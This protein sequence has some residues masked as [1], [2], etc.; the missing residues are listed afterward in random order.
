M[1]RRRLLWGLLAIAGVLVLILALAGVFAPEARRE[2]TVDRPLDREPITDDK[3]LGVLRDFQ[4]AGTDWTLKAPEAVVNRDETTSLTNPEVHV[5]RTLD[6]GEQ[7]VVARASRGLLIRQP[8][9]QMNLSGGVKADLSGLYT[10]TISAPSMAVDLALG[11]GRSSDRVEIV[12]RT[13][14]GSHSL[15][16]TGV[17]LDPRQ[18]TLRIARDIAAAILA[19]SRVISA[20]ETSGTSRPVPPI[21]IT[22]AGPAAADGFERAVRLQNAVHFRQGSDELQADRVNLF[23]SQEKTAAPRTSALEGRTDIERFEAEG[24]V[25]FKTSVAEGGGARL[26]RTRLNDQVTL[27]GAPATVRQGGSRITS[28]RMD[29][30]T[31]RTC[32]DVPGKGALEA[33]QEGEN[34]DRIEVSWG[35]MM[36]FDAATHDVAFRGEVRLKRQGLQIDCQSLNARLDKDNRRLLSCRAEG[37]VRISGLASVEKERPAE[38]V[39]ARSRELLYDAQKDSLRL[40]GDAVARRGA[41]EVRGNDIE[42]GLK[43]A[44]LRVAGAGTLKAQAPEGD[45]RPALEA[46]WS[47]DMAYSRADGK[48]RLRRGVSIAQGAQTLKAD[49]VEVRLTEDGRAQGLAA[50]GNVEIVEEGRLLRAE[51]LTARFGAENALEE[52]VATGRVSLVERG[53]ASAPGRTLTADK[54]AARLGGGKSL[55]DFEATGRVQIE[56]TAPGA[57]A[58]RLRADRVLAKSGPDRTLQSFDALGGVTIEEGAPGTKDTRLLRADRV[59]AKT[60]ADGTLQSFDALGKVTITEGAPG[61]R[62]A[63]LLHADRVIARIGSR[64]T[65]QEFDAIGRVSIDDAGGSRAAG[66]T[67]RADRVLSRL[68]SAGTLEGFDASGNVVIEEGESLEKGGRV[69]RA[70]RLTA[71][72]GPENQLRRVTAQGRRVSLEESR[73]RAVGRTLVWDA[74]ADAGTLTGSPVEVYQDG[75]RLFGE[76][77]EFSRGQGSVRIRAPRRVEALIVGGAPDFSK[78]RE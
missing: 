70:E 4:T 73:V 8:Q 50:T 9:E 63:R 61:T 15:A 39:T 30:D 65:L 27:E 20:R 22:C 43:D 51:R 33:V 41:Q 14:E 64:Q 2:P 66:R 40:L 67:L 68:G 53:G 10:G 60:G 31:A 45:N 44:A 7:R 54:V 49:D 46:G 12:L 5:V 3:T 19:P 48:A 35:R 28:E 1:K 71:L 75:N 62:E 55:Q 34:P 78:P 57:P 76:V 58:R 37:D 77:V 23:F 18:R 72:L 52:V 13:D 16:G 26:V 36:H 42:F 6:R 32:V 59:L 11:T 38:P 47:G 29:L 74:A 25:R 21:E 69:V 24:N 17:D 56:E